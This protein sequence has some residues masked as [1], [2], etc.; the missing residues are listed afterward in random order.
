MPTWARHCK[1]GRQVGRLPFQVGAR[2]PPQDRARGSGRPHARR[3]RFVPDKRVTVSTGLPRGARKG[4]VDRFG[5]EWIKGPSRTAGQPF[6]WD[7]PLSKL[8]PVRR[9]MSGTQPLVFWLQGRP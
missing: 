1:P 6:E 4:C 7:V 8:G 9:V 5:T 2:R 3:I